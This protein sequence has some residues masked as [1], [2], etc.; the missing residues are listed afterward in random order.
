M[1]SLETGQ[2]RSRHPDTEVIDGRKAI[3]WATQCVTILGQ[4]I[5][6]NDPNRSVVEEFKRLRSGL[7]GPF[8]HLAARLRA[9]H[10]DFANGFI[11]DLGSQIEAE[12]AAD[13]LGQAERL[14]GEG[15]SGKFDHVPAAVLAGSVLEK[16]L[17]AFCGRQQPPVATVNATGGP[18]TLAP[19]IDGLKKAGLF[20]EVRA[21]QLRHWA[22][23]RNSAAHGKFEEFDRNQVEA[24]VKGIEQFLA[25]HL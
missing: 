8:R 17:R 19:L 4:I 9:L 12:I 7:A 14:L 11:G 16:T 2:V 21:K 20:N 23:I 18:L 25:E 13:Y 1:T 5:P 15:Q 3:Q 6:R 24:M 10:D 22:D